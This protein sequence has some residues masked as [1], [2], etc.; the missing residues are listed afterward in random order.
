MLTNILSIKHKN[1]LYQLLSR[2]TTI[3]K[4]RGMPIVRVERLTDAVHVF[5]H[6]EWHMWGYR[7]RVDELSDRT[8]AVKKEQWIFERSEEVQ[9]KYAIPSA[10]AAYASYIL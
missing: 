5:S 2:K 3:F 4:K 10:F 1:A 8:Q 9:K 7:V 6:K